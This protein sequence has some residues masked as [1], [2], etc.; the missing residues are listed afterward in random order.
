MNTVDTLSM[1]TA[2]LSEL[3]SR[4]QADE[5]GALRDE[6]CAMFDAAQTDARRRTFEPLPTEEH[7]ESVLL[8]MCTQSCSEIVSDVWK[9]LHR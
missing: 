5:A 4:L 8:A 2:P 9:A 3:A 1:P 7:E 6:Y